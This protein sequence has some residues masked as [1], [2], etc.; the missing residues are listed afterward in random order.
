MKAK[1]ESLF[2]PAQEKEQKVSNHE[3]LILVLL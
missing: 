1:N 3:E 2:H